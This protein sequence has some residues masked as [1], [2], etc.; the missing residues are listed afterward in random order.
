MNRKQAIGKG[1]FWLAGIISLVPEIRALITFAQYA[2]GFISTDLYLIAAEAIAKMI[3]L[4]PLFILMYRGYTWARTAFA[5]FMGLLVI[6]EFGLPLVNPAYEWNGS[7]MQQKL[8]FISAYLLVP[9]IM[10]NILK[11]TKTFLN[12]RSIKAG[13]NEAPNLRQI[14]EIGK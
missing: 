4:I 3:V 2:D 7:L 14:D 9:V 11:P 5:L 13:Q 6:A 1:C 8:W 12:A 10:I